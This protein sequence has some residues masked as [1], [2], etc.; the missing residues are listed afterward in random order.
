MSS[1][2]S[3]A[4]SVPLVLANE[5]AT[6]RLA[7]D[8]A[9][10]LAPGDV[11]TLSGDLGAGKT[12]F[13]RAVIRRLAGDESLEVPSPTFTLLQTYPLSRFPVVHADLYRVADPAEIVELGFEEALEGAA[14]L[15]EWP[16]RSGD[17]IPADRLD[18]K[19]SLAPTLGLSAR[20]VVITPFGAFVA[21]LSRMTA[22]RRFIDDSGFAEAE[23]Q[24]LQGD[25][26]TRTY[27]RLA[28]GNR[29]G[30]LMNAPRRPDGPPI[31]H[32][33][34][35][36]A[37]AHLAED[38]KPYVAMTR[39]LRARGL[40]APEIFAADLAEG[41]LIVEDLGSDGVVAGDP[42]API[43]ERYATA[44]DVL[45]ALHGQQLPAVLP[46]S[47]Q[48][49]HKLPRYDLN[50]FLIECELALDW[51]FPHRGAPIS[52]S[53]RLEFSALWHHMLRRAIA[54]PATWVLRDF[55]SPNLLW[56]PDRE[57]LARLGLID[58][59]DAQLGPPPYDV[60]SLLH[61]A[62][63]DVPES[64]EIALLGRYAKARQAADP[65]FD[66]ASFVEIYAVLGAQRATKL[67]GIFARLDRR[68]HKPQYLRHL[69]RVWRYL[70]RAL[71]HPR[72]SLLK[73][74]YDS[75]VPLPPEP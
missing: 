46:V 27:E 52:G 3:G 75:H 7:G 12:T 8:L 39:G 28:L 33:L 41:L 30:V 40:S 50:A 19:F 24:Y 49:E 65:A 42:P 74:W 57:D 5:Q 64:M 47:P 23:R 22:V 16:E 32:G 63:V 53:A 36:S 4:S 70:R 67:L 18:I 35:Y 44:I 69:P 17:L 62:R 10:M 13:A 6:R 38:V 48:V 15:I 9:A 21:R 60:V 68:D 26:S 37:I 34:S 1:P 72:L 58:F 2:T 25:A 61:D 29:R 11:I 59:Q 20:N 71:S 31:R 54:M 45:V 66:L 73:K 14:A 43:E 51:Y 55:H 56:L